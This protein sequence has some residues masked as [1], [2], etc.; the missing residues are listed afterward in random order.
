MRS[1]VVVVIN[2]LFLYTEV[3]YVL[4]HAF[5]GANKLFTYY[6]RPIFVASNLGV[7]PKGCVKGRYPLS[8]T[9]I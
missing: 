9:Q 6:M 5:D 3:M 7:Y 1:S 2:L 4:V 8:K